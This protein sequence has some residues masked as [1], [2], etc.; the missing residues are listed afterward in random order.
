MP[1][2][3]RRSIFVPISKNK[4]DIQSCTNYRRIKL[5]SHTM[6]LWE[7]VVEHRLREMTR[8][9]VNQLGFMPGRSTMEAIFMLRQ[10]MERYK[11]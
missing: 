6:K 3:W 10:V 11:E 4:G 9:T 1:E 2:E 7:R 8:I 5:M